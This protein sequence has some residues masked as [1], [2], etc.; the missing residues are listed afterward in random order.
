M[1]TNRAVSNASKFQ[2]PEHLRTLRSLTMKTSNKDSVNLLRIHLDGRLTFNVYVTKLKG[3]A[4]NSCMSLQLYEPEKS[5]SIIN[6]SVTS[7]FLYCPF[8][9]SNGT[10]QHSE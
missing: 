6:L 7:Q 5:H 4:K 10:V 1:P 2:V 3:H 9:W 8:V